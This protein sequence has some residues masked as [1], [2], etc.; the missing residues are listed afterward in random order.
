M[1][2]EDQ[3]DHCHVSLSGRITIDSS[4]DI[5]SRLLQRLQSRQCQG[6]TVDLY[7]VDY[8]DT[9]GLAILVEM[10][11]A[12]RD[13]GKT[14]HLSRLRERPRYLFETSRLLHLFEDGNPQASVSALQS[15]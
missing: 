4:P 13:Q 6:L 1:L 11:K 7:N 2:V 12:A 10:L 5:R 3:G 14:F 9:S 8:I 15:P